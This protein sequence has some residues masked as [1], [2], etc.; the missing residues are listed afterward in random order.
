MGLPGSGK[1]TLAREL[2]RRLNA[3]HWNADEVRKMVGKPVPGD[4]RVEQAKRMRFL[5]ETVDR[6]GQHVIAD[7]VC[8]TEECR[9]AFGSAYTIWVDRISREECRFADT[10]A[11][12][13]AP[14]HYDVK[15]PEQKVPTH[16]RLVS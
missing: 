7:F 12:F 11:L 4:D 10:A 2:A 3:V 5:C 15:Y 13:E 8:P 16:M 6:T 1:T 14:K 9:T